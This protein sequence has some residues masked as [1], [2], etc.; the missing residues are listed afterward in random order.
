[1]M[2]VMVMTMVMFAMMIDVDDDGDDDGNGDDCGVCCGDDDD[3]GDDDRDGDNDVGDD[4]GDDYDDVDVA[5]FDDGVFNWVSMRSNTKFHLLDDSRAGS[6]GVT[7]CTYA[8]M[9]SQEQYLFQSDY[10]PV[11][12][13]ELTAFSKQTS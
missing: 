12:E 4:D 9:W 6:K 1:M 3:D 7:T 5:D 8:Y 2:M 13:S 10:L 11:D